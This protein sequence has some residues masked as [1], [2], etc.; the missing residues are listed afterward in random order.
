MSHFECVKIE[1]DTD[2]QYSCI[3]AMIA[4]KMIM[5]RLISVDQKRPQEQFLCMLSCMKAPALSQ[6][7][8]DLF[9]EDDI[10]NR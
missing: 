8:S 6:R 2:V 7:L 4:C 1:T 10:P 3:E 5:E 9:G